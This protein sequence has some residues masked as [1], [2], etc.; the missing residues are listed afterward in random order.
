MKK[1]FALLIVL[2]IVFFR[3]TTEKN[4]NGTAE[5]VPLIDFNSLE[6][7]HPSEVYLF[8]EIGFFQL[9]Q[10]QSV[11]LSNDI[12]LQVADNFLFIYDFVKKSFYRFSMDGQLINTI[13][14][15][16]KG[17][18]EHTQVLSFAVNTQK[19]M[20]EAL[21]NHGRE[22]KQYSYKGDFISTFNTPVR[23]DG[24]SITSD[25]KYWF[26]SAI[27]NGETDYRLHYAETIDN[28]ESFLPLK[29]ECFGVQE[30]N[31]T[32]NGNE[33]W[34]RES[35]FPTIYKLDSGI[36]IPKYKIGFGKGE[37]NEADFIHAKDPFLYIE[38]INKEGFYTTINLVVNNSFVNIPIIW[39]SENSIEIYE[40]LL[41]KDSKKNLLVY[42]KD[43][44]Y[45]KL[46]S[47]SKLVFIDGQN[48][49]H[50][51][52][53]A[54]AFISFIKESGLKVDI[55]NID[56]QGNQVVYTLPIIKL[57]KFND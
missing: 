20:V 17:P 19:K 4:T 34:F 43:E 8:S 31:F 49:L 30:Q 55:S 35:F 23:T 46:I 11:L 29:T 52:T 14:L 13:G 16:G 21:C 53:S 1:L 28:L 54:L 10:K 57:D 41:F 42:Y 44:V 33:I 39:Q 7:N 18:E 12:Q 51:I 9:G 38:T 15:S 24:F 45:K 56:I 40:L 37:I 22:I 50:Y 47:S 27:G 5:G 3:C 26:Y 25:S 36:V 2:C 48:T 32:K 6:K